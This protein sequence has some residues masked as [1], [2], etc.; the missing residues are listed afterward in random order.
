MNPKSTS[1]IDPVCGMSVPP[2][3]PYQGQRDGE[4]HFFCSAHC[5]DSFAVAEPESVRE[6]L[7]CC[8]GHGKSRTAGSAKHDHH[9]HHGA[10]RQE[11]ER[12]AGEG[13]SRGKYFC[14]M[15]PGVAAEQAGDCP[16]CGMPLE[17]KLA[18]AQ[19]A[20][21][22]VYT[23][24]MHPEVRAHQ[25]GDCPICGMALEPM[26]VGAEEAEQDEAADLSRRFRVGLVL[27]V[28]VVVLAMAHL[29]PGLHLENYLPGGINRGLQL[30][31][32]TPVVLWAGWPFFVR[33]WRSLQTGSLNMFTLIGMGVGAAYLFSVFA[34][35]FPGALPE[36]YRKHSEVPLYFEAAAV[37]VVLVLLGQLLEARARS[38]T[39][40][41]IKA[42]LNQAAK[43]ATLIRDG[44]ERTVPVSQ[45]VH[46]DLVR[47]R[48][49][50]KVPVDGVLVE[51]ESSLDESMVTGESMPVSRRTGDQ[52]IGST[53]NQTGSFVMRAERVGRETMLARIVE[54]VAAAQ[55]SRAPIQRLADQV[56]KYFVPSVV[57]VALLTFW[58]WFQ[59]GPE[60]RLA[61][62]LVNA[63]AVLIIACPCALG[64]ATPMSITVGIGR[65]AEQGILIKDAAALEKMERVDTLVLD[66]TGTL[67]EG[68]P[69]LIEV[70]P[71]EGYSSDEVLQLA[72]A[73]EVNSEHPIGRAIVAGANEKNIQIPGVSQFTS[74]T[75]G[76]VSGLVDG[77]RIFVG[78]P[79][80]LRKNGIDSFGELESI[81]D[82]LQ[83]R[84]HTVVFAAREGAA[85]GVLAVADSLKP[86]TIPALAAI[87]RLGLNL[88]MLT[89]DNTATAQSIASA[90]GIERFQAGVEPQHKHEEVAKLKAQGHIVAMAGDG[91]NDAPALAVA[92]VGIAMGTGT[93]VAM[94]SAG[95]TLMKGD[96]MAIVKTI[97]LSRKVMRNIRQ[98]LFFAFVYNALGVP[99]AA[100]VLYPFFGVLLSPIL[101]S[102]AMSLSSVCVVF[103]AL[104]LRNARAHDKKFR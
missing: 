55:R 21:S 37:I 25:P 45:V 7:P 74:T 67:T 33:A 31:L 56:S 59:F 17:K 79:D 73:V 51:G 88:V 53:V 27:S 104:R 90:A 75:G 84:G 46:G 14:P 44:I 77:R 92:D 70:I 81:A 58:I 41:A 63:V 39:S 78:K 99:I 12:P 1:K 40:S 30:V 5:R 18:F 49:G 69:R 19:P 48:P 101:A 91:I 13:V 83:A 36:S 6:A 68:K 24:P 26:T 85:L 20:G 9:E 62:A 54:M 10:A 60:P 72:A 64:L 42:L 8:S 35:L 94:E 4:S 80:F 65:G 38:R 3:T 95:V 23:C 97:Q 66:K 82:T 29:I 28:P 61:Y 34:L 86:T 52:V 15:C 71:V 87:K 89:G 102:A 43:T 100:G 98:N 96:L 2:T 11:H 47:V 32:S 22:V 76:G 57:V 16:E 103:N 50:E 93:D